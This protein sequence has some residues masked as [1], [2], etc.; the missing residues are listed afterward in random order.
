MLQIDTGDRATNHF[1]VDKCEA[2]RDAAADAMPGAAQGDIDAEIGR[3]VLADL[4]NTK[5]AATARLHWLQLW[6]L[7]A[8]MHERSPATFDHVFQEFAEHLAAF[9]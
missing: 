2:L 4:L 8:E 7:L 5:R 1:R 3:L 9:R 6:P